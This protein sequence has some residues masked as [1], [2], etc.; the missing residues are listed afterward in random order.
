MQDQFETR[1]EQITDRY[2]QASFG[3]W[4]AL[5]TINGLILAAATL[6]SGEDVSLVQLA[7]V[8]L[9]LVA[10]TLLT[11]NYLVVKSTYFRIGRVLAEDPENLTDKQMEKDL[12]KS[13]LKFQLSKWSENGCLFILLIQAGL[14]V[15]GLSYE[16]A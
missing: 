15:F 14:L 13:Q 8:A 11:C 9:A 1:I 2:L 7:V 16:I 12:K 4:N 5:L 10:I 6:V 3:L